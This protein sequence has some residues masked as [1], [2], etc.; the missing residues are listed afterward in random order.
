MFGP[1]GRRVRPLRGVAHSH[2]PGYSQRGRIILRTSALL[3]SRN[4]RRVTPRSFN[5]STDVKLRRGLLPFPR[6]LSGRAG[7]PHRTRCGPLPRCGVAM[8]GAPLLGHPGPS[9]RRNADSHGAVN[10]ASTEFCEVQGGFSRALAHIHLPQTRVC[11]VR[12]VA[13][14]RYVVG[15]GSLPALLLYTGLATFSHQEA[16]VGDRV[17]A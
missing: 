5:R 17:C 2:S 8:M 9:G 11:C 10:C 4:L 3:G 7:S 14:D 15:V 12:Y 13:R 16:R 6:L 1:R